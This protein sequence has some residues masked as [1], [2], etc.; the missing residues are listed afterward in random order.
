MM[1]FLRP[2]FIPSSACRGAVGVFC[3][4]GVSTWWGVNEEKIPGS[5][6]RPSFGSWVV[7]ESFRWIILRISRSLFGSSTFR[8]IIS[9]LYVHYH[10]L[11]KPSFWISKQ[12]CKQQPNVGAT[13]TP[14]VRCFQL[15]MAWVVNLAPTIKPRPSFMDL[16]CQ[17][18]FFSCFRGFKDHL[19]FL[20][21]WNTEIGKL[22]LGEFANPYWGKLR[23]VGCSST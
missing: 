15:W 22:P 13:P 17:C 14:P 19:F 9:S 2:Q 4:P 8:G 18:C 3:P 6:S 20:G 12:I 10:T 5:P 23:W 16:P 7:R 1:T 11:M 21:C